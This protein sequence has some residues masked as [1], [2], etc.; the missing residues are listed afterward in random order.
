MKLQPSTLTGKPAWHCSHRW[1]DEHHI[2]EQGTVVAS[3]EYITEYAIHYVVRHHTDE[4]TQLPTEI[5]QLIT[6][7]LEQRE[8]KLKALKS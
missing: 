1:A 2:T 6:K 7:E 4:R 3:N 8:E 5:S